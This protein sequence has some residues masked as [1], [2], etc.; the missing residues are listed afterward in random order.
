MFADTAAA[1][2]DG[3]ADAEGKDAEDEDADEDADANDEDDDDVDV[4]DAKLDGKSNKT[5]IGKK[6]NC[7]IKCMMTVEVD[8]KEK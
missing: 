2:D 5:A 8:A 1:M 4:E 3:D 6:I 7:L